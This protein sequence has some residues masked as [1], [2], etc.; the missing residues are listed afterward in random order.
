MPSPPKE[1]SAT[2]GK[3]STPSLQSEGLGLAAFCGF[4]GPALSALRLTE[5]SPE[6]VFRTVLLQVSTF[7]PPEV[8]GPN[9]AHNWLILV[10]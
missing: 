7:F 6:D 3:A 5:A 10:V 2:P 8:C 9:P 4:L 1:E